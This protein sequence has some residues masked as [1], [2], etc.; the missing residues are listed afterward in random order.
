MRVVKVASSGYSHTV[1]AERAGWV[2]FHSAPGTAGL[3][4]QP[5]VP[6][7]NFFQKK[8]KTPTQILNSV[9]CFRRIFHRFLFFAVRN[10][11][12]DG[13]VMYCRSEIVTVSQEILYSIKIS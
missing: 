7:G 3:R 10:L 9:F 13:R 4:T 5:R 8:Q 1:Y 11:T 6:L 12:R 2:L